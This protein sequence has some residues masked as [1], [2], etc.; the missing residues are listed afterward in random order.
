MICTG[1]RWSEDGYSITPA[2]APKDIYIPLPR[3]GAAL[4]YIIA[5]IGNET[6]AVVFSDSFTHSTVASRLGF[7]QGE[8]VSAG[9]IELGTDGKV[10][11]FGKSLSLHLMS[12]K[13]DSAF[14]TR[15]LA[16]SNE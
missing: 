7:K 16:A 1:R 9:F 11:C 3:K 14:I 8:P 13:Q 5:E 15:E 6:R 2:I 10:N 12:R 4:K